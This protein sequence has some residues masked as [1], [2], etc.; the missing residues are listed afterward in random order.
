MLVIMGCCLMTTGYSANKQDDELDKALQ[1]IC[2]LYEEG[3]DLE[4]SQ[5]WDYYESIQGKLEKEWG[6]IY[7]LKL[8]K[9]ESKE[10]WDIQASTEER[11]LS[12]LRNGEYDEEFFEEQI[13]ARGSE[14]E[15]NRNCFIEWMCSEMERDLCDNMFLKIEQQSDLFWAENFNLRLRGNEKSV[16]LVAIGEEGPIIVSYE[17]DAGQGEKAERIVKIKSVFGYTPHGAENYFLI[18]RDADV[19]SCWIQQFSR[20]P[21]LREMKNIYHCCLYTVVPKRHEPEDV[22]E[23]SWDGTEV[24]KQYEIEDEE[25]SEFDVFEDHSEGNRM[26]EGVRN[27]FGYLKCYF[28]VQRS[29]DQL[30]PRRDPEM[31]ASIKKAEGS[32]ERLAGEAQGALPC[33]IINYIGFFP[34]GKKKPTEEIQAPNQKA[35]LSDGE[36]PDV[37]VFYCLRKSV[38]HD[39]VKEE[40]DCVKEGYFYCNASTGEVIGYTLLQKGQDFPEFYIEINDD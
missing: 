13:G 32:I 4:V 40:N 19:E 24:V 38:T 17:R 7:D 15:S 2:Q 5:V 1:T 11:W 12:A 28:S 29:F 18:P 3:K 33:D 30:L 34:Q 39:P 9:L 21:T 37:L 14:R 26:A 23:F 25:D 22:I 16:R 6:V 20:N 8:K 31:M 35:S 36:L 27:P 10:K